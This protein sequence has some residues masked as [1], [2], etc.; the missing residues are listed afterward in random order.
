MEGNKI[1]GLVGL[2]SWGRNILRNLYEMGVL[3][4]ACD[5]R[6]EVIEERRKEYS[7]IEFISNYEKLI[8]DENV[9]AVV[10]ATPA[11]THYELAKKA[12]YKDKHVFVEKPLAMTVKE[13]EELV[14][15]AKEKNKILMVGHLL[16]YHPAIRKLKELISIGK[17]GKIQYIYSNRLNIGKL[18]MEEN[19]LWSFAPHDISVIIKLLGEEPIKVYAY[20]GDYLNKGIYDTTISILEFQNGAKAH[21]FVSWL[22]PFKEQKLV[23]VGT[24]AMVVF[25][26][27]TEEKLFYYP[28][29][30]EWVDGKIPVA[31]KAKRLIVKVDKE[32]PLKNEIKH[33]LDCITNKKEP[34]TDGFEALRVLRVLEACENFI[35]KERRS[36]EI[37]LI[38][39]P[40]PDEEKK[41]F[42]HESSYIDEG[43]EIGAGTK[44]WHYCHILKNSKIGKNCILGQNVMVGPNVK[45]GDR[46]KIQ[47][48]VSVYEGVELEDEVF[49]GPS[50]V[51]TNVINPRSFIERKREFRSTLVKRGATLGA[52]STIMCGI[53][54]GE[55]AFIGAG[56]LV[57]K[58]VL[59]YAL[60]VGV[61][62]K[63]IGW[64][65]KCGNTLK[66]VFVDNKIICM[67]CNLQYI[68]EGEML[69]P[70]NEEEKR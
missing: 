29:T 11:V 26:D 47:N 59:P 33:F 69:R 42:V 40:P 3:Y 68:L 1:I 18:R 20:G 27:L 39:S 60:V 50:M 56:A 6:E 37:N 4:V 22:H 8:E 44:I 53:A 52:N 65:C 21:I 32:E 10:I 41:Y 35:N 55:Y 13:G 46:V 19:I 9:K 12:L 17:L 25:D 36:Y 34:L 5:N 7:G 30:I 31:H 43:V 67:H 63:Q 62:A 51:F 49:C 38:N 28:H 23:V 54:I 61:P 15:T 16:Q 14:K 2:G 58:D 66:G 64:V 24:E 70:I 57:N 45:I 48:N